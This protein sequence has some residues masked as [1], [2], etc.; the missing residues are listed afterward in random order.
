MKTKDSTSTSSTLGSQ[1]LEMD[2]EEG[3][4]PYSHEDEFVEGIKSNRHK[5][6][7]EPLIFEDSVT[8]CGED[9]ERII[10]I[11]E[12]IMND[13]KSLKTI[14]RSIE[15]SHKRGYVRSISYLRRPYHS[16]RNKGYVSSSTQ[17]SPERSP[18]EYKKRR[19]TGEELVGELRRI[20]PPNF[21]GE[22]KQGEDVEAWLIGLKKLF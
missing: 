1:R 8:K 17:S 11:Q 22:V 21:D 14:Q 20:K 16:D 7:S 4:R 9:N 3:R 2:F 18:V 19:F 5:M 10:H 12:Q 6:S 13:L 15:K